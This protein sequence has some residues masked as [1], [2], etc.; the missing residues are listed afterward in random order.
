MW[1]LL[2]SFSADEFVPSGAVASSW[3]E[4]Q[5]KRVFPDEHRGIVSPCKP[6]KK[7][8]PNRPTTR[9]TLPPPPPVVDDLFGD[10]DADLMLMDMP[11]PDQDPSPP[12][13]PPPPSRNID[14]KPVVKNVSVS[15]GTNV[16]DLLQDDDDMLFMNIDIPT[17]IPTRELKP[18]PMTSSYAK[19]QPLAIKSEP[20]NRPFD[21]LLPYLQKKSKSLPVADTLCIK[22]F[23]SSITSKLAA[24]K[25][26]WG[27][28]AVI[29]DGSASIEVDFNSD[30]S[31]DPSTYK[32][33]RFIDALEIDAQ[34]TAISELVC[35]SM[36]F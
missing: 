36:S 3:K 28:R 32:L 16:A 30:V 12:S 13:P 1:R 9:P 5:Q 21:Y 25:L 34:F 7:L 14:R 24:R 11:M 29:N 17:E 35:F 8:Q 23:I 22:A 31:T 15:T 2:F 20:I 19:A 18:Q 6:S 4:R 26:S 10:D 27:L 33:D